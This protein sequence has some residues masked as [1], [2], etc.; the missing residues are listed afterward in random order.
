MGKNMDT[1]SDKEQI[2]Q[3]YKD[4]YSYMVSKDTAVL[5]RLMT[6]DF[7][8]IHMTGLKQDKETYLRCIADGTLNYYSATH[9]NLEEFGKVIAEGGSCVVISSK[10]GHRLGAIADEDSELLATTPTEKLL[11]LPLVKKHNRYFE[12]ISILQTLQCPE[13]YV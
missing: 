1:F 11:D 9:E 13:S 3:T 7:I 5:S 10:S 6:D 12:S 8:L 2:L 4:M